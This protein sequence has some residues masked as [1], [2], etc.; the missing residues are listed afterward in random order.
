MCIVPRENVQKV[1]PTFLMPSSGISIGNAGMHKG[2]QG[3]FSLF[4]KGHSDRRFFA[5]G[6]RRYPGML[7]LIRTLHLR[8]SP[9]V[10]SSFEGPVKEPILVDSGEVSPTYPT[11]CRE[12]LD[13]AIRQTPHLEEQG[14]CVQT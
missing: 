9:V 12:S 4:L 5:K 2:H 11:D 7:N 3:V 6:A 1:V 14:L 8:K 13:P 10:R